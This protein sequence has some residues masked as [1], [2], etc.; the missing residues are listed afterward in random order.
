MFEAVLESLIAHARRIN[1]LAG[2]VMGF[3]L[4]DERGNLSGAEQRALA[5]MHDQQVSA[6]AAFDAALHALDTEHAQAWRAWL[7]AR[8]ERLAGNV[9]DAVACLR[10]VLAGAPPRYSLA[11]A[12]A[13]TDAAEEAQLRAAIAAGDVVAHAH[14]YARWLEVRGRC[15][16]AI[17]ILDPALRTGPDYMRGE[18]SGVSLG[19]AM[20]D[21]WR[22]LHARVGREPVWVPTDAAYVADWAAVLRR[23]T[24]S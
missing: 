20:A 16:D 11:W 24:A 17:A 10:D 14:D 21:T 18:L 4:A 15:D 2:K 8:C 6:G 12:I 3:E 5:A 13:I 7:V 19:T 1:E 22:R 9:G 23:V